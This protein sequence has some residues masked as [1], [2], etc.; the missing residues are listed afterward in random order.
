MLE[1]STATCANEVK[2]EFKGI[3]EKTTANIFLIGYVAGARQE[4]P[5][6]KLSDIFK[7]YCKL[8]GQRYSKKTYDNLLVKLEYYNDKMNLSE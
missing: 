2:V 6:A 8:I 5:N 7:N 4:N 3:A 1:Y